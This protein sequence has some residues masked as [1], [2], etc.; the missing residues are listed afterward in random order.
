LDGEGQPGVP[1]NAGAGVVGSRPFAAQF[2]Q[3]PALPGSLIVK[4]EGKLAG[5]VEGAAQAA[6][7]DC[8]AVKSLGAVEIV[9]FRQG[10]EDQELGQGAGERFGVMLGTGIGMAGLAMGAT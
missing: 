5:L 6:V 8:L 1:L 7:V 3:A 4:G 10:A 2:V 9:Q